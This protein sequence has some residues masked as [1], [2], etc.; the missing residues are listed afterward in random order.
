M[1]V[2]F[3]DKRL[4]AACKSTIVKRC[5]VSIAICKLD[6]QALT[7][8]CQDAEVRVNWK[9]RGAGQPWRN[10]GCVGCVAVEVRVHLLSRRHLG[11]NGVEEADEPLVPAALRIA[12]ADAFE[13]PRTSCTDAYSRGS[14]FRRGP[15][16]WEAGLGPVERLDLL[17]SS[18]EGR[19]HGRAD[20]LGDLRHRA[21]YRRSG[22]GSEFDL[23][24]PMPL[25]IVRARCVGRNSH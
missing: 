14:S 25:E 17:F 9:Q 6:E 10:F 16:S 23:F 13:A 5:R 15:S 7:A 4:I 1:G 2:T 3:D 19:R 24:H 20:R 22:V 12:A 21:A 11:L 8:S 18:I